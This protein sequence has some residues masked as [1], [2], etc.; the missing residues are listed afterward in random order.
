[1]AKKGGFF[2]SV[3]KFFRWTIYALA[4]IGALAL[5]LG[6]SDKGEAPQVAATEPAP[7]LPARA[8]QTPETVAAE[9]S[10][11]PVPAQA[12]QG[13]ASVAEGTGLVETPPVDGTAS[14]PSTVEPARAEQ[15]PETVTAEES[16][17][18]VPAEAE[19]DGAALPEGTGLETPR[20]V[21]GTEGAEQAPA[22]VT[23]EQSDLNI[24]TPAMSDIRI[25]GDDATYSVVSVFQRDDGRIEVTS[26]RTLNGETVQTTRLITCAPLAVGIISEGNGARNDNP[27]LERIPLGTAA[28][29][30]AGMA[31]GAM[32]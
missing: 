31:C 30:I 14:T 20:P 22:A 17:V 18:A 21:D 26:D 10:S 28:A 1:M 12:E 29:T 11:T 23:E 9:E 15:T 8:E 5:W 2:S 7:E 6:W 24:L 25:P 4:A 13:G 27:D 3:G 19:R 16:P 32:N